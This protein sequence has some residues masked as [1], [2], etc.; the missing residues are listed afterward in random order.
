MKRGVLRLRGRR[1]SASPVVL[2]SLEAACRHLETRARAIRGLG[3]PLNTMVAALEIQD[4]RAISVLLTTRED[5]A[6]AI[7]EKPPTPATALFWR[8]LA[9]ADELGSLRVIVSDGRS[10]LTLLLPGFVAAVEKT[11]QETKCRTDLH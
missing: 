11:L 5:A 3:K 7:A 10:G 1:S 4:P 6:A 8:W 2:P 9:K